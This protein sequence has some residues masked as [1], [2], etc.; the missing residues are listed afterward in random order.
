MYVPHD[1]PNITFAKFLSP[2]EVANHIQFLISAGDKSKTESSK[3]IESNI[4]LLAEKYYEYEDGKIKE[5][6]R[7]KKRLD[8][9]IILWNKKMCSCGQ[10]LHFRDSHGFWGCNNFS[11]K[12]FDHITFGHEDLQNEK[13]KQRRINT[14]VRIESAW[15][16]KILKASGLDKKIKAKQLLEA[17]EAI[18]LEDLR[19]KYN[20]YTNTSHSINTYSRVNKLSKAEELSVKN[21]L[22]TFFKKVLYQ[23]YIQYRIDNQKPKIAIP[24]V[25]VSNEETIFIIEVKR[26]YYATDLNQIDLYSDLLNYLKPEKDKRNIEKAFIVAEKF[27]N[28]YVKPKNKFGLINELLALKSQQEV[29]SYLTANKL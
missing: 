1:K 19:E 6:E 5:F 26:N 18:G 21:H 2:T 11:D 25:I 24:D 27:D 10:K 3:I 13:F 28:T 7:Q 15:Y 9:D 4:E 12:T 17:F 29:I 22:E 8:E 14:H 23:K 20:S 16:S